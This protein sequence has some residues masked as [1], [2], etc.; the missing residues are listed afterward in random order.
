MSRLYIRA[1]G[2]RSELTR[3]AIDNAQAEILYNFDGGSSAL[4]SLRMEAVNNPDRSQIVYTVYYTN[5]RTGQKKRL[6]CW[7]VDK[8][9]PEEVNVVFP[10]PPKQ[11][12]LF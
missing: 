6:S 1:K 8:D 9:H 10:V 5:K 11:P 4:G 2:S 7:T 12:K 3:T